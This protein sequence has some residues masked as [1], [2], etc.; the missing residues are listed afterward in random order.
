MAG[1]DRTDTFLTKPNFPQTTPLPVIPNATPGNGLVLTK[2]S[3]NAFSLIM[4]SAQAGANMTTSQSIR[5]TFFLNFLVGNLNEAIGSPQDTGQA[6]NSVFAAVVR[7]YRVGD[8][9]DLHVMEPD[10]M[11]L[12]AI[13]S[14]D[15]TDCSPG[16][17]WAAMVRLPF[18]I[19]PGMTLKIRYKS[20]AGPHSWFSFWM[21][22]GSERSPGPGGNPYQGYR[23][24]L[25]LVQL[26]RCFNGCA[27]MGGNAFEIDLNDNYSRYY[28]YTPV[29]TGY[30][31][32]YGI[33]D[34]YGTKWKIAPHTVYVAQG[35]GYVFHPEGKPPFEQLP[36]N[37]STG[38]HDLVMSWDKR[39]DTIYE[40]VDGKLV[41]AMYMEYP[42]PTYRDGFDHDRTKVQAMHF[43]IQNA[44]IPSFSPGASRAIDNDGIRGGWTGVIQEISG[45]FGTVA[46]PY[47]YAAAPNGA[48]T[49]QH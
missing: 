16:H 47:K 28:N 36:F 33:P 48:A 10:G 42:A 34:N 29:P 19:R 14:K 38:F 41:V 35:N 44:A 2:G 8:P 26:P 11:H 40:F 39:T 23:T 21:F 24:D 1:T 43:M 46:T 20:P 32:D 17:V 4:G 15:R 3:R 30:Q 5:D 49:D 12:R 6:N 45:W 13:C 37:W 25:S 7:H 22:S 9:N 18:E 27:S 31:F